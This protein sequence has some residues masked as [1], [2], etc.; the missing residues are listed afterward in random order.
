MVMWWPHLIVRPNALNEVILQIYSL[1]C[2]AM[3][4][5]VLHSG[6]KCPECGHNTNILIALRDYVADGHGQ[7]CQMP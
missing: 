7:W 2:M 6:A 5:M 4:L 3:W 1:P